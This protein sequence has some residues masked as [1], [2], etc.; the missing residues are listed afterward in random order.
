MPNTDETTATSLTWRE[1]II[2][3]EKRGY[4]LEKDKKD[5]QMWQTCAVGEQHEMQPTVVVR[6]T[7]YTTPKDI[8]LYQLGNSIALAVHY[9][10]FLIA[11]EIL[12]TIEDRVL[13]LK[14]E[15]RNGDTN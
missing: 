10:L 1:R 6:L 3:A 8:Q 2:A 11:A 15:M 12:D 4:F 13:Q 7:G 5:I 14:R 9:D